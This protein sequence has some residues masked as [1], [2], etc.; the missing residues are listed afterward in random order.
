MTAPSKKPQSC[1]QCG[2]CCL[3]DMIAYVT[4][5]DLARWKREGRG[6]IMHVIERESAVWM[7]DHLV[8]ATDG[9]Y[10]GPCPFLI[11]RGDRYDCAIYE[12]R[13][14]VCRDYAAGSSELCSLFATTPGAPDRPARG[15]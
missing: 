8:S 11:N 12:T 15:M 3:A 5:D 10:I 1:V 7:G 6:D 4:D 9:H 2:T 13:P 14:Q